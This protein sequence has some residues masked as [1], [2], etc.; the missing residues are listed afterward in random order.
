MTEP[1]ATPSLSTA[2]VAWEPGLELVQCVR[3]LAAAR[4][5]AGLDVELVVVDNASREFPAAEVRAAWPGVT[6]IR[7]GTNR[8]FG[9]AANQA[10][11]AA[12]GEIVLL[13]NP[14]TRAVDEPFGQLLAAFSQHPEAVAVAPR[15]LVDDPSV[16]QNL[17]VHQLRRLPTLG[18]VAREMLLIDRAVPGNRW[19]TRDRYLDRDQKQPFEVEQ[20]AAA[21]L[22]VRRDVFLRLGGF[23]EA[24]VPAWFEDVDLCAR[25]LNEGSILYWPTSR[26]MHSG[27]AAARTLGFDAFLPIYH[28]NALVYWRKHHGQAVGAAYRAFV[29]VGMVLRLLVVPFS[30]AP[31]AKGTAARGYARVLR[32]VAGLGW[33][34]PR[35]SP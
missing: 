10:V 16:R 28:R 29:A 7:N 21:A 22:A 23:D 5:A 25:L 26:F 3:S 14:D 6:I 12:H 9:P 27:G 31:A 8:G 13:L 2:I 34:L 30:R 18:H 24:F 17:R 33:R 4:T 19:L 1:S 35:R 20:P 11:V 15:L 32:G